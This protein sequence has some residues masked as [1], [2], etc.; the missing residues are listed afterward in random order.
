MITLGTDELF[1]LS[2]MI[3]EKLTKNGVTDD[4]VLT[5]MVDELSFKKIDE[6]I[7]IRL[8]SQGIIEEDAVF[9]PSENEITVNFPNINII[10]KKKDA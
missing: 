2:M 9:E 6:D 4:S 7:F 8:Q 1:E 10:I 3:G 5:I